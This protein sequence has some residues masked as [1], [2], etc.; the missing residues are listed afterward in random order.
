MH[1]T[2]APE[3]AGAPDERRGTTSAAKRPGATLK[4]PK[5]QFISAL[6]FIL[7]VAA[8]SCAVINFKQQSVYRLPDDGIVWV[9][10]SSKPPAP[11]DVSDCVRVRAFITRPSKRTASPAK[12]VIRPQTYTALPHVS[13]GGV[14]WRWTAMAAADRRPNVSRAMRAL[15][16]APL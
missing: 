4:D 12:T 11:G 10:R 5:A 16:V 3:L 15:V 8:V 6:L 2:G 7:T 13:D 9:D 1:T 14:M